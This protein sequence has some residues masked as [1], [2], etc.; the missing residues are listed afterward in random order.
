MLRARTLFCL[1]CAAL[2]TAVACALML[3]SSS[4]RAA[5]PP[6]APVSFIRDVAPILKESCFGC[7]GAKNPKGKL[8]MTKYASLRHGGTKDDPIVPG[9][10]DESQLIFRVSHANPAVRMPPQAANK[11]LSAEQIETLR[12]WIAQGAEYKPHWAFVAP[13][14]ITPPQVAGEPQAAESSSAAGLRPFVVSAASLMT[15]QL[16]ERELIV[17]P[18]LSTSSLTMIYGRRGGGKT[19]VTRTGWVLRSTSGTKRRARVQRPSS[20]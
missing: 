11:V 16:P 20:G 17:D 4:A 15:L 9:K 1:V 12:T 10:P 3:V 2:A 18:W 7:H 19:W 8:D 14:R 13:Q 5:D 6:K